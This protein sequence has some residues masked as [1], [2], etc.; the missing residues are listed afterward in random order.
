DV[1]P[2]I[3]GY[4]LDFPLDLTGQRKQ[5]TTQAR[6]QEEIAGFNLASA[7]WS[8]RHEVVQ[9]LIDLHA[10]EEAS[11]FWKN[12]SDLL[13][14]SVTLVENEVQVGEVSDFEARQ[15]RILSNRAEIDARQNNRARSEALIRLAEALGVTS[16]ALE[17]VTFSYRGLDHPPAEI[18]QKEARAFA[19]Q[20][21]P[22]LLA[23]LTA[24]AL[25]ESELQ[26]EVARQYPD[27][28]IGPGYELDQGEGK[29]S[30]SFGFD[31]PMFDRN[32][33]PIAVATAQR[34][35]AA[36]RFLAL[37]NHV[38]SQVDR[39]F[40]DYA[41]THQELETFRSLHS[42][43]DEQ[44]K[45]LQVGQSVGE[46][47]RLEVFRAKLE[48]ADHMSAELDAV[49]RAEQSL[50]ALEDAIQRPLAWPDTVWSQSPR[51]AAA[52]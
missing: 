30:L 39:A 3:L 37:Q 22:D 20:N 1:S 48:L 13:S 34:E 5:R 15:I 25:T 47:S 2:W 14:Q 21:R 27:L 32:K 38:L 11:A 26:R 40:A 49:R 36:A 8:V 12:Q 19:A 51:T 6:Y 35:A 24:Y 7:A 17:G 41:S 44:V 29:W 10:A 9:A 45:T 28:V 4:V 50:A 46:V 33:G 18:T 31:L 43:Y 23:S 52:P 42:R 16:P